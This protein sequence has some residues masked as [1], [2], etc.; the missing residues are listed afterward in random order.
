VT[1][2][3][4]QAAIALVLVLGAACYLAWCGWRGWRAAALALTRFEPPACG[5][6]L[7]LR[8]AARR[9]LSSS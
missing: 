8:V 2:A 3:W 9:S 4:M 5:V 7:S 6:C 1:A